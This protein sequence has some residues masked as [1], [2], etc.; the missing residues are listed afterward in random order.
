LIPPQRDTVERLLRTWEF[1]VRQED[2]PPKGR[3]G[4]RKLVDFWL[5]FARILGKANTFLLLTIMYVVVIGPGA[6]VLKVFRKDLL[7]RNH[8]ERESYWYDKAAVH[9]DVEHSKHQF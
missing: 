9:Q 6:L 8:E 5:R 7:D 2:T 4:W 3:S 1:R